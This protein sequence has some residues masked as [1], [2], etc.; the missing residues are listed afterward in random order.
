[1][2]GE[3]GVGGCGVQSVKMCVR[4]E[5]SVVL[6]QSQD[7]KYHRKSTR[8]FVS[9][10]CGTTVGTTC[11]TATAFVTLMCTAVIGSFTW[12]PEIWWY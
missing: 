7:R 11:K 1:M 10:L 6:D 8:K 5:C 4:C 9:S 3:G 2:D 12:I